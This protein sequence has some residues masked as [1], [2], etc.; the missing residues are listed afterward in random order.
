MLV[1]DH[2]PSRVGALIGTRDGVAPRSSDRFGFFLGAAFQIQDDLLN[3]VGDQARYGKELD[4]D[5]WEGKRTLMLIRLFQRASPPELAR[6]T[7]LLAAAARSDGAEVRW[8]RERIDAYGCIEHARGT[9]HA[10]AGAA[11]HEYEVA[12]GGLPDSRDKS[13]LRELA[14]WMLHRT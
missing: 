1:H 6:V 5:I 7:S 12:L 2:L 14:R 13:F 4:G 9:A 8:I 3:L 10:L 11:C